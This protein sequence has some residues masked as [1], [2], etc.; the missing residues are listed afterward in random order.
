VVI[1]AGRSAARSRSWWVGK[2]A[3]RFGVPGLG[4]KAK[5]KM[6]R[7]NTRPWQWSM[8]KK[9]LLGC[10]ECNNEAQTDAACA[11]TG[12]EATSAQVTTGPARLCGLGEAPPLPNSITFCARRPRA[13]EQ[14]SLLRVAQS[15]A[16]LPSGASQRSSATRRAADMTT[17]LVWLPGR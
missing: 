2:R 12:I 6:D 5:Q 7:R 1:A 17:A 16:V 11:A 3:C 8:G 10:G 13:S 4:G 15:L 9:C 14:N